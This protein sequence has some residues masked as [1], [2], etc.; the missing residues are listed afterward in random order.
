MAAAPNVKA[1]IERLSRKPPRYPIMLDDEIASSTRQPTDAERKD[2]NRALQYVILRRDMMDAIV[3]KAKRQIE[4]SFHKIDLRISE[5]KFLSFLIDPAWS[6]RTGLTPLIFSEHDTT[7]WFTTVFARPIIVLINAMLKMDESGRK[8]TTED[9]ISSFFQSDD[10]KQSTSLLSNPGDLAVY[11]ASTTKKGDHNSIPDLMVCR[12]I[13]RDLKVHDENVKCIV[14]M[15][16]A[17]AYSDNTFKWIN[18][19]KDEKGDEFIVEDE[20]AIPFVWPSEIQEINP[21]KSINKNAE[22][23]SKKQSSM[24]LQVSQQSVSH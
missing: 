4:D 22:S 13:H 1:F 17:N 24:I 2:K 21:T 14:E 5:H 9:V 12:D 6:I 16:T 15:K 23:T 3:E 8:K 11:I 19:K 10:T 7:D 20:Y 18:D